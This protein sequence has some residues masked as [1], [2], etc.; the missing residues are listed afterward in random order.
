M[1]ENLEHAAVKKTDLEL[2]KAKKLGN[3]LSREA[4]AAHGGKP[5]QA[6]RPTAKAPAGSLM[7]RLLGKVTPAPSK[8]GNK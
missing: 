8:D 5:G 1:S 6:G 4:A 7:D 2:L 3:R